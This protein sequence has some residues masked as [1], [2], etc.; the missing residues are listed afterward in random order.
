VVALTN[1]NGALVERYDY[2]PYGWVALTDV[3]GGGLVGNVYGFTGR[4]FDPE[5]GLYYYRARHYSPLMGRFLSRDPLGVWGDS[6]NF[7]NAYAYGGNNPCLWVD[8]TGKKITVYYR[9]GSNKEKSK[10]IFGHTFIHVETLDA[11]SNIVIDERILDVYP[12]DPEKKDDIHVF[13]SFK[14]FEAARGSK[15]LETFKK[16][17]LMTSLEQ[18]RSA[19]EEID[20]ID[21]E[22]ANYHLT[23]N[24][25][26]DNNERVLRAANKANKNPMDPDKRI[27]VSETLLPKEH[28]KHLEK[29]TNSKLHSSETRERIQKEKERKEQSEKIQKEMEGF[30]RSIK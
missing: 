9:D 16:V 19:I 4:R 27:D 12:D 18:D 7:G 23:K 28:G 10:G 3:D 29:E 11:H 14:D 20:K 1:C 2:D 13:K 30:N 25:C 24:N 6:G 17:E 8:P 22:N 15:F 26:V 5:I 21:K